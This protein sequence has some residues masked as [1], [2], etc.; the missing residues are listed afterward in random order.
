MLQRHI[1]DLLVVLVL[2]ALPG[3]RAA[4]MQSFRPAFPG[5][6]TDVANFVEEMFSDT[7]SVG[8]LVTG[9]MCNRADA[10]TD[11]V[12]DSLSHPPA[13]PF[14]SIDEALI[15]LSQVDP[16]VSW[17]RVPDGMVRVRAGD[18]PDDVLRIR[19]RSVHFRDRAESAFAVQDILSAPEIRAYFKA[20][21]IEM[22]TY[23]RM[24]D[25]GIL[26]GSTKGLPRLS[27]TLQDVT[28]AEALD[29]VARFYHALWIYSD[30]RKGPR[31][32]V[33]ITA[34]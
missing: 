33:T 31:R 17:T 21:H 22:G 18:V 3:L 20:N 26:P 16:H 10:A 28:L 11:V 23:A 32:V 19:L 27:D 13:G 25:L 30:C 9:G 7:H 12:S 1:I 34:Y 5:S 15:A 4:S 29:H 2:A 24:G 14:R 8:S 6:P